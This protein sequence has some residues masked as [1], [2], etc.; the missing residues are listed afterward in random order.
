MENPEKKLDIRALAIFTAEALVVLGVIAIIL[1]FLGFN[2]FNLLNKNNANTTTKSTPTPNA[3]TNLPLT[4][5]PIG[6]NDP[7]VF[8]TEVR[9]T[10]KGNVGSI[11][12]LADRYQ[13]VFEGNNTP[14]DISKTTWVSKDTNGNL[15]SIKASEI[16]QGDS[17]VSSHKYNITQ[18]EWI[19]YDI[20]PVTPSV[21]Q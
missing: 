7:L 4:G 5:S 20:V 14:V 16:K 21:T 8:D 15:T 12:E 1:F 9:Y 11:T 19:L 18:D 2:P 10:L 3:A 13:I 6:F 17:I